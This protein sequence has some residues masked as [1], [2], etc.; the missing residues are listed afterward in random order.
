MADSIFTKIIKG[1]IPSYKI[2]ED[3]KTFAFLDIYPTQPGHTLVIPKQQVEFLW[4]LKQEDYVALMETCKKVARHIRE[5]LGA[6]YVGVKVIG[7]EVPH[8]H[9]HLIP[10]NSASDF[11]E[12]RPEDAQ[13]DLPALAEMADQLA[14]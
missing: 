3:E 1:E 2:Y 8:A 6:R 5:T 13:P 4:D 10:L 14:F 12:Q 11:F 9:I 7:E